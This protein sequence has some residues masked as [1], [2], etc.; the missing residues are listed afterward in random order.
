VHGIRA[1]ITIIHPLYFCSPFYPGNFTVS[2]SVTRYT[3]KD[4]MWGIA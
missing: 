1:A 2:N 4:R 3:Y